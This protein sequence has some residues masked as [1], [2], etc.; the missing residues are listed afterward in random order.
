MSTYLSIV[1]GLPELLDRLQVY[2]D[3]TYGHYPASQ[4]LV[5]QGQ[6]SRGIFVVLKGMVYLRSRGGGANIATSLEADQSFGIMIPATDHLDRTLPATIA[7]ARACDIL[8]IS[9][10]QLRRHPEIHRIL[11]DF[12]QP[13]SEPLEALET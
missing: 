2:S 8:F 9:R 5:Y 12:T 10:T 1:S 3:L 6:I 11:E 4:D 7:T 13:V